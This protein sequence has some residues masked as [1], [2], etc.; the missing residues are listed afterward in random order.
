[1]GLSGSCVIV[2][3]TDNA[4]HISPIGRILAI[5]STRSCADGVDVPALPSRPIRT[6]NKQRQMMAI[7][8][9]RPWCEAAEEMLCYA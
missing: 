4:V 9:Y 6:L 3:S 8:R 7:R 1:M 5:R 2:Q